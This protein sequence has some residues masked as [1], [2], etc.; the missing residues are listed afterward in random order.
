MVDQ[1]DRGNTLVS[2][3]LDLL[4]RAVDELPDLSARRARLFPGK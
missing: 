4:L 2:P 3:E 1:E